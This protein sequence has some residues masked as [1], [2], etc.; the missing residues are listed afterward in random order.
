[1]QVCIKGK[2][3]NL[4]ITYSTIVYVLSIF[5]ESGMQNSIFSLLKFVL[6]ETE[7]FS[8]SLFLRLSSS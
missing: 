2:I 6:N 5:S 4:I 3:V 1:M 8:G 7:N